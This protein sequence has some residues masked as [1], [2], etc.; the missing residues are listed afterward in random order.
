MA[1]IL[2]ILETARV[3]S[4]AFMGLMRGIY[5]TAHQGKQQDPKEDMPIRFPPQDHLLFV[6]YSIFF[7][8]MFLQASLP[9][10]GKMISEHTKGSVYSVC[11]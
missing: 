11:D 2:G 5:F 9:T 7:F 3:T 1:A 6:L 4:F 10:F 8:L